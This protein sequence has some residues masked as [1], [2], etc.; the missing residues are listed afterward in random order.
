MPA[1]YIPLLFFSALV[2]SFPIVTLIVFKFIRPGSRGGP[3]E[4]QPY[5][6]GVLPET[7]AS[8]RRSA[9]FYIIAMVFVIFEVGTIFLFPWAILFREWL[10]QHH[11]AFA[12]LSMLVFVGILLVGYLWLYKKGAFDLA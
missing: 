4:F 6:C 12:L 3:A 5:E 9:R 2:L 1:A 10:V 7:G 8:G 11:A